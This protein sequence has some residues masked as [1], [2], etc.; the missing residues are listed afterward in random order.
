[1]KIEK[2]WQDNKNAFLSRAAKVKDDK[3]LIASYQM[4][5]EQLKTGIT[6]YYQNDVYLRQMIVLL[7]QEAS[8]GA[9]I[10]LAKSLPGIEYHNGQ[11]ENR[12]PLIIR[13]LLNPILSYV[14]LAAGFAFSILVGMNKMPFSGYCACFFAAG[15]ALVIYQNIMAKRQKGSLPVA[16]SSVKL[17]FLEGFITRQVRLLD[18][19]ISD[20]ENLLEDLTEIPTDS[21]LD[22]GIMELCQYV[23]AF[24]NSGYP[25]E[26]ALFKAESI[27]EKNDITWTEFSDEKRSFYDIMP[28]KKYSRTVY[29]ALQKISDGTLIRK[30]QYLESGS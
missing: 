10:L 2:L 26:T 25:K 15:L 30:G 1:M 24:A 14:I 7:F 9:E 11:K 12:D 29:P 6:G 4:L 23:W 27:L 3:D 17:D 21:S 28:T 13:F 8:Q 5:L 22:T 20:C 16:L 18:Q 19:H